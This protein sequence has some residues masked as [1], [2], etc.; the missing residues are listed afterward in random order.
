MQLLLNHADKSVDLPDT[1]LPPEAASLVH[2]HPHPAH[3]PRGG[4]SQGV[5]H[6]S[7]EQRARD[8]DAFAQA[9]SA[10]RPD[11]LLPLFDPHTGH[12][13]LSPPQGTQPVTDAAFLARTARL[14]RSVN[15]AY[16]A[17]AD[18]VCAAMGY[19]NAIAPPTVSVL[20]S[21]PS[22]SSAASAASTRAATEAAATAA[23]V[24]SVDAGGTSGSDDDEGGLGTL[25]LRRKQR[26]QPALPLATAATAAT[27]ATPAAHA[28]KKR[29]WLMSVFGLRLGGGDAATDQGPASPSAASGA[30]AAPDEWVEAATTEPAQAPPGATG[31]GTAASASPPPPPPPAVPPKGELLY[32]RSESNWAGGDLPAFFVSRDDELRAF[33]VSVRG[34]YNWEDAV[35]NFSAA[36]EPVECPV[37]ADALTFDLDSARDMSGYGLVLR[38]TAHRGMALAAKGIIKHLFDTPGAPTTAVAAAAMAT[39]AGSSAGGTNNSPATPLSS[40]GATAPRAA[41]T[42]GASSTASAAVA[43]VSVPGIDLAS[44]LRQHPGY[45]LV[46]AGHS[47]GGGCAAIA[48]ILLRSAYLMRYE[49]PE[50][51]AAGIEAHAFC[52]PSCVSQEVSLA[53]KRHVSLPTRSPRSF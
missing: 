33:V 52:A 30:D 45:G 23:G 22:T 11:V 44:L 21:A 12:T 43:A 27:A 9:A 13:Y 41:G 48:A 26:A 25:Y 38:G 18:E 34:T 6:V 10:A 36:P 15:A 14:L 28:P 37:P 1:K 3:S 51:Y 46:F 47:Q 31:S 53:C 4:H 39:A 16:H 32:H 49:Y 19:A 5:Q 24:G 2:L 29:R 20:A 17:S 35:V 42:S 40:T 8:A 50:L 7:A